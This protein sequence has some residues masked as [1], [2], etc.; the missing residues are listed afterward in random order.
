MLL[1]VDSQDVKYITTG[2]ITNITLVSLQIAQLFQNLK[3]FPPGRPLELIGPDCNIN[4]V[5]DPA[6]CTPTPSTYFSDV[7][8]NVIIYNNSVGAGFGRLGRDTLGT[9]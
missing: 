5:I 3:K 7:V 6:D 4:D 9:L 8:G 1:N 2:L